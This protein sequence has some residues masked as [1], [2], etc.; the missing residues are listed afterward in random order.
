[1]SRIAFRLILSPIICII[2][3][4]SNYF[5]SKIDVQCGHLVALISISEQQYGHFF[6][7]G[8]GVSSSF[9]VIALRRSVIRLITFNKIKI[10]SAV[11]RNFHR[12]T[13]P[14]FVCNILIF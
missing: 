2:C 8:A 7:V 5:S 11:I 1:M 10:T 14:L 12:V 13:L 4:S 9:P 3:N 6:V